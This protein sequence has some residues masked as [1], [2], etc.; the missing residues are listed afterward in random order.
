MSLRQFSQL[1][2]N[3]VNVLLNDRPVR[4]STQSVLWSL[5]SKERVWE[6]R[7]KYLADAEKEAARQAY[8]Q[9]LIIYETILLQ[10]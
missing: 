4:A 10:A 3:L 5:E 2:T 9:A 1:H 7:S 8:D 6:N